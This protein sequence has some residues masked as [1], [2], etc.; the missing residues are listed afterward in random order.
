MTRATQ[1][2]IVNEC[3]SASGTSRQDWKGSVFTWV[4]N[5]G[6]T[7][8]IV[9]SVVQNV[10][11]TCEYWEWWR[12]MRDFQISEFKLIR[13][14]FGRYIWPTIC[15]AFIYTWIIHE[16]VKFAK[17]LVV[18]SLPVIFL[19]LQFGYLKEKENFSRFIKVFDLQVASDFP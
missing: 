17:S 9:V 7:T 14:Q 4:Y 19:F 10:Q 3:L 16:Q 15:I 2:S 11:S 5:M 12:K 8:I 18:F 6:M 1:N 13:R